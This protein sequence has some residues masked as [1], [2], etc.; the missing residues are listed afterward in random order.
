MPRDGREKLTNAVFS[1]ALS[2]QMEYY[3]YK[4]RNNLKIVHPRA[5]SLQPHS[6]SLSLLER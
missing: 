6:L 5:L 1:R 4:P 2:L 3:V